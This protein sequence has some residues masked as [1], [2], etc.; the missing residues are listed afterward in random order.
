MLAYVR[1]K[2]LNPGRKIE[3][4]RARMMGRSPDVKFGVRFSA[5]NVRSMS[6]KWNRGGGGKKRK[7][8]RL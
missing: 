2:A 5:W 8:L 7:T 6:T 1:K 3:C 4:S